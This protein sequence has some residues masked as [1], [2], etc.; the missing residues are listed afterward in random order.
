MSLAYEPKGKSIII[1]LIKC[2]CKAMGLKQSY[3]W[4]Y[5]PICLPLPWLKHH[6]N[7][8]QSKVQQIITYNSYLIPFLWYLIDQLLKLKTAAWHNPKDRL[9]SNQSTLK[10]TLRSEPLALQAEIWSEENKKS[11]FKWA[12]PFGCQEFWSEKN[13]NQNLL[14]IKCFCSSAFFR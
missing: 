13:L 7:L 5:K 8:M 11:D 14:C 12:N 3:V 4:N 10:W 6:H 2:Y 1:S 9:N